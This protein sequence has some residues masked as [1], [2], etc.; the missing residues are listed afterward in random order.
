MAASTR[1]KSAL[2]L[3]GSE[4]TEITGTK[5]P[6]KKQVLCVLLHH[7]K[8]L[9]KA[10][11]ASAIAVI[12]EV[13]LFWNK[14]RIPVRPEHHAVKQLEALHDKW[15]KL[16]K[17]AKRTSET[18]Q[19]KLQ[20]FVDQLGDLFDIAH[21]DALILVKNPEDRE[22]LVAQR[23]KGRR[24]HMGSADM[25]L[26]L[27]E[28]RRKQRQN[29]EYKRIKQAEQEHTLMDDTVV[30]TASEDS[31]E[32]EE[33]ADGV[34]AQHPVLAEPTKSKKEDVQESSTSQ[35]RKRFRKHIVS[36]ELAATLDRTKLSDR[37][38][39]FMIAAK[40]RSLGKDVQEFTI[41][42][43]SIRRA[44]LRL[45]QDISNRLKDNFDL[46]TPL[47][48]H[49][50]GK[51]LPD[52]P[53]KE[54]VD[55]LP[56]L[57]SGLNTLQLLGVPKLV[58]GTG[59]AQA[60]AVHQLFEDWGL[61]HIVQALCFDTTATNTGQVN[62]VCALLE[63]KLDRSLLYFACRHHVFE[64]GLASAFT[65]CMGLPLVLMFRCSRGFRSTGKPSTEQSLNQL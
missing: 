31:T 4:D 36:P 3:L 7:H 58:S 16:K 44:R 2:W 21:Q 43:S 25:A 53:G 52:L 65:T 9:K 63:S 38:A 29:E 26:N 19:A 27:K 15:Q 62:G 22:F 32:E 13:L 41:N 5:L 37:K 17:N 55:R 11:H 49:W 33:I 61:K 18:Q 39:T 1:S 14:A 48:V 47:T 51:L 45:R 23:E 56:V 57:V 64:L 60:A 34:S 8:T 10:L 30:L 40:A 12:K 46:G 54:L 59:E 50:D 28:K 42:R 20:A 6:S 35:P 24:G